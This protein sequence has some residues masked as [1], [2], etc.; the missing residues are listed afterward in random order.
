MWYWVVSTTAG[1]LPDK[2][3]LGRWYGVPSKGSTTP[4]ASYVLGKSG[5][6]DIQEN[7]CAISTEERASPEFIESLRL[8]DQATMPKSGD[9]SVEE[10]EELD[11]GPATLDDGLVLSVETSTKAKTQFARGLT[12]LAENC[13]PQQSKRWRLIVRTAIICGRRLWLEK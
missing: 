4:S 6:V 3:M 12:S 10:E 1:L 13:L 2:R 5:R 9:S 7:V 8:F 11:V